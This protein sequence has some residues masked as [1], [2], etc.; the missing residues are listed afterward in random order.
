MTSE[1]DSNAPLPAAEPSYEGSERRDTARPDRRKA[2]RGGRRT[3]DTIARV[4]DFIYKLLT[5]QPR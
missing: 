3:G 5:E 1:N 2:A 4:A